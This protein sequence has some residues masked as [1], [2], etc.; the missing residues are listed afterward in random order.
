VELAA[1][2]DN[3]AFEMMDATTQ[4]E[5]ILPALESAHAL[6]ALPAILAGSRPSASGASQPSW[7]SETIVLVGL[8]G[9]GDKDLA[10]FGSWLT[11]PRDHAPA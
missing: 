4:A 10:S 5:G 2:T 6:A 8:S 9:R 3:A 11:R 7:L 1:A